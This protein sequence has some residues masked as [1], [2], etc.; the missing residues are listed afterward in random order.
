LNLYFLILSIFTGGIVALLFNLIKMKGR[1]DKPYKTSSYCYLGSY[2]DLIIG[3][4][5]AFMFVVFVN[6]NSV[7]TTLITSIAAAVWVE[8]RLTRKTSVNNYQN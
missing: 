8:Y 4:I 6:P 3:A 1:F 5:F 2:G 7:L